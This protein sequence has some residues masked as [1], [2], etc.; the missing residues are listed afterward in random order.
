MARWMD[1]IREEGRRDGMGDMMQGVDG[2]D[3][4]LWF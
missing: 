4:G 3:A 1:T 2:I